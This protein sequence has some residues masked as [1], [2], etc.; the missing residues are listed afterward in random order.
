[1]CRIQGTAEV[2]NTLNSREKPQPVPNKRVEDGNEYQIV[3]DSN[4]FDQTYIEEN[5]KENFRDE[6]VNFNSQVSG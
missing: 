3:V 5:I 1:M 2:K 6:S 4:D